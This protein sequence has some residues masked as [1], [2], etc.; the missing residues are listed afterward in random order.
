MRR[1]EFMTLPGALG[2]LSATPDFAAEQRWKRLGQVLH[3]RS[4]DVWDRLVS[5][6]HVVR[7]GDTLRMY[8]DGWQPWGEQF[9][10]RIGLAEASVADPLAWSRVQDNP[11]L[12]LGPA[13]SIDS[14]WASY[15][16][17]VPISESHWH[18]YY[19]GWGGKFHA[20]VP[21][22]KIWWTALAES[23]DAGRTWRRTGRA[24]L[25]LGRK[26]AC[27]EHGTGSCAVIKMGDEYWMYYTAISSPTPDWF[28]ISVALAVST[29][30]GHSFR[31]HPAGALINIPPEMG[32][33]GSTSSKPFVERDGDRFRMWYSCSKDGH[34]YRIHYAESRDG[35]YFKWLPDPVLDVSAT[36]W[37]SEMTCYPCVV[38]LGGRTLLFYDGNGY[39][40]IGAAELEPHP[41]GRR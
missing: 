4:G 41:G 36:G 35:I 23:D 33:P 40:G 29:D 11:V 37:D 3:A 26:G 14:E 17:V 8:F 9:R 13:G 38:H 12:D 25:D 39:A 18:M 2:A 30:G 24:L 34:H 10:R 21:R 20:A 27:D 32:K 22:R 1:R 6:P 15:P 7:V 16:W 5:A 28:R 31:P 19:A